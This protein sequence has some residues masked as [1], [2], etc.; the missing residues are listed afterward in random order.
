MV[1]GIM[2]KSISVF[3]G[4]RRMTIMQMPNENRALDVSE[5]CSSHRDQA[6]PRYRH[7]SV[8]SIVQ[9]IV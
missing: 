4:A 9:S 2:V 1:N 5:T 3:R 7:V 8:Q 6:P